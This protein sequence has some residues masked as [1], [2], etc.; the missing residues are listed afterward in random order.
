MSLSESCLAVAIISTI[1]IMAVPSFIEVRE[2]YAVNAAARHVAG[3]MHATR[4]RAISQN[5]DCRVRVTSSMSYL[6]ECENSTWT[7]VEYN[8]T[9]NGIRISANAVP[10]FHRRGNVSPM[11]TIT[12]SNGRGRQRSVIVNNAGRIRVQ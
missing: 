8:E 9:P 12:V 10:E 1:T 7:P 6:I 5:R 3:R 2:T 11:A 4:I